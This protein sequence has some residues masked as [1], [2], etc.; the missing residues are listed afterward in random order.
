MATNGKR[1]IFTDATVP[2]AHEAEA[3]AAV[4]PGSL[5]EQSST[6]VAESNDASTV[7]GKQALFA[8]YNTLAAGD[9]DTSYASGETVI[10]RKL[11]AD[12]TANV[13]VAA[14]T[15]ITAKG[16]G[17]ASNGAGVLKI[18]ATTGADKII[19]YSDEIINT[20]ASITLVKVKG[21]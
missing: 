20:G 2:F 16:I 1:K 13:L 9:V 4:R 17:L 8:D 12:C 21:A 3:T 6:G 14:S 18:A 15:N 7:F 10:F 5:V 11:P 19:A